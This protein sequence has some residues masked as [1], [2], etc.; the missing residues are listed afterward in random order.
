MALVVAIDEL[1]KVGVFGN[2]NS[3][4]G[5]SDSENFVVEKRLRIIDR[6]DGHI[7]SKTAEKGRKASIGTLIKEKFQ[8]E[9]ADPLA[10]AAR[11]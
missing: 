5:N 3:S 6:H 9:V 8:G 10:T 1:P 4:L 7:M 2:E 11:A